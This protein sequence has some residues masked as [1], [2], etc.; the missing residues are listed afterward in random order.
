MAAQAPSAACAQW[1]GADFDV[2]G[3][4]AR[5]RHRRRSEGDIS[6]SGRSPARDIVAHTRTSPPERDSDAH[7]AA[8]E[9]TDSRG[10]VSRRFRADSKRT[11]TGLPGRPGTDMSW[12]W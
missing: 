11:M 1:R 5:V 8:V 10:A 7:A 4:R 3:L 9:D 6:P 12:L 2:A